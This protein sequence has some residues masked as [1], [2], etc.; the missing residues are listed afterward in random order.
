MKNRDENPPDATIVQFM[1]Q[2][3]SYFD[4]QLAWCR[5]AC[6]LQSELFNLGDPGGHREHLFG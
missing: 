4:C 2:A 5:P 1:Q 3:G 6:L